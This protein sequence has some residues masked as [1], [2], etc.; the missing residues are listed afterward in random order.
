M[1]LVRIKDGKTMKNFN[2]NSK[3]I[4]TIRKIIPPK[5]GECL[6]SKGL[7]DDQIKLW[8]NKNE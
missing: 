4:I 7:E 6:L 5:Y 8:I 1:K 3:N 2:E